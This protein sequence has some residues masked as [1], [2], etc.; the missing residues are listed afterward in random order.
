M[1]LSKLSVIHGNLGHL[2]RR[3]EYGTCAMEHVD[4]LT[5]RER[6]YVEGNFYGDSIATFDKAIDASAG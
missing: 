6:Y 2:T 3:D 4:R 5:A 1:A